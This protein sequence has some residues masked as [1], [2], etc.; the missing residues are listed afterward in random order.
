[1]IKMRKFYKK[2]KN[3]LNSFKSKN[4]IKN[5]S[6]PQEILITANNRRIKYN[7]FVNF[8]NLKRNKVYTKK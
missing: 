5:T 2:T 4:K 6:T 1:M 7:D 3:E 8:N